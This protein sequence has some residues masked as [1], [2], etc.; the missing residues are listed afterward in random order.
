MISILSFPPPHFPRETICNYN[1]IYKLLIEKNKAKAE[2][3]A[4]Q[5]LINQGECFCTIFSSATIQQ[6]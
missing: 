1:V 5:T 6:D 3:I 2:N 4:R